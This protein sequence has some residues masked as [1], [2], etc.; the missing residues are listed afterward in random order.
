MQGVLVIA[1]RKQKERTDARDERKA[2][3]A[4]VRE[5]KSAAI[6]AAV[7]AL[8]EL[9]AARIIATYVSVHSEV[10]THELMQEL[11]DDQRRLAVPVVRSPETMLLCEIALFDELVPGAHGIPEPMPPAERADERLVDAILVPG[12]RFTSDGH[13]LGNGGG[14][15]DRVLARIP[16]AKRIGLAF[17]E[18]VVGKLPFEPH[19]QPL[20]VLVTDARVIR[21]PRAP[22]LRA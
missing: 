14:Y 2:I 8:P 7:L 3:P 20:D 13:R 10:D 12:L 11:I 17:E 16:H 18:Q 21:F 1:E 5:A 22:T 9:E 19:D 4:R 15:F 6:R